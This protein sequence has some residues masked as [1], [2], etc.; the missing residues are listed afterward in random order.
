MTRVS[1]KQ[2]W[3]QATLRVNLIYTPTP[4]TEKEILIK[5]VNKLGT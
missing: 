1:F 4:P 5:S 3:Y 2:T